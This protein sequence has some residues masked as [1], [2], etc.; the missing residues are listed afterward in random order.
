MFAAV[1][2]SCDAFSRTEKGGYAESPASPHPLLDCVLP[3]GRICV[4]GK[5]AIGAK[6]FARSVVS[7]AGK[8]AEMDARIASLGDVVNLD[9]VRWGGCS[10]GLILLLGVWL[11]GFASPLTAFSA[12]AFRRN[13]FGGCLLAKVFGRILGI[14]G[15]VLCS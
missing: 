7:F 15:I 4:D 8:S 9:N 14:N 6:D 3:G 1:V 2:V 10:Q 13:R 12:A 5:G 11:V